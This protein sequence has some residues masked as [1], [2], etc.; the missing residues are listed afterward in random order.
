MK[1]RLLS[2]TERELY[3][4]DTLCI[5][6]ATDL[7]G[8]AA[9]NNTGSF[10]VA[11]YGGGDAVA[12]PYA[13]VAAPPTFGA[14]VVL[15]LKA[16]I[17]DTPFAFSDASITS[18]TLVVGDGGSSN[19]YLTSSQVELAQTPITYSLGT[20]TRNVLTAVDSLI[21]LFTGTAAHD[22]NTCTAGSIR[23]FF[24]TEDLTQL[25]AS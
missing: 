2:L 24:K 25:P 23:L 14:G 11:P 8:L 17:L 22:L 10:K 3:Q 18:V 13:N 12:Q 7:Q 4:A 19:R 21:A 1:F 16:A 5:L 15:Q 9:S 20:G 6:D